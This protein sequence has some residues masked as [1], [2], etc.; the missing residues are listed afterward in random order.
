MVGVPANTGGSD[1]RSARWQNH[2]RT[3]R[4][5]LVRAVV[6]AV[7]ELGPDVGMDDIATHSG[8]AKQ[9]FY[10]YFADKGDLRVTVGRAVARALV[11]DVTQAFESESSLHDMLAA[12]IDRYLQLIAAEVSLYRFVT[13]SAEGE[14]TRVEPADVV[15]DFQTVIGLTVARLIGDRLRGSGADAGAAEPWGFALVGAVRAAA[16]R[17]LDAP[18]MSR[19]ALAAYLTEF[20]WQG[21]SMLETPAAGSAADS[22]VDSAAGSP[23]DPAGHGAE[24]KPLRAGAR[25]SPRGR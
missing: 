17:W 12:G 9:V 23:D 20:A 5:E 6:E 24:V 4:R 15:T 19:E 10:R 14:R 21:L 11:A 18:A 2:R 8:I 13:R 3:R 22:A 1:G 16:D 25:R 7:R